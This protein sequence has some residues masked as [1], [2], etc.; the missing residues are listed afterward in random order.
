MPMKISQ[1]IRYI[2]K[3][4]DELS[5]RNFRVKVLPLALILLLSI[6]IGDLRYIDQKLVIFGIDSTVLIQIFF[7]LGFLPIIFLKERRVLNLLRLSVLIQAALLVTQFFMAPGV[8]RL[9]AY[10]GFHFANGIST[11]CGFYLFAFALNNVERLFTIVAAKSYFALSYLFL[12]IKPVAAFF[13]GAGSAAVMLALA[14]TAFAV[15]RR[16]K[17]ESPLF[18]LQHTPQFGTEPK[19]EPGARESGMAAVIVLSMVYFVITLMTLYIE[20]NEATVSASLFGIGGVASIA[21]IFTV[22]LLFNYSALHLWT[23]SLVS[24]VLG[25]G[26]LFYASAFAVN[27]GSL[28]YGVGEGLGFMILYYLQGG[29][30]KRSGSF[31]LLQ[32]F[33]LFTFANYAIVNSVFYALFNHLNAP[34]LNLAFP[35]VFLLTLVCLFLAPIL[36]KRLFHTDWTDGYHM[37]DMPF[38]VEAFK[39][40]EQ[41]DKKNDLGLT[42]R[43]REVFTLLLTDVPFKQIAGIMKVSNATVKF[44]SQNLYRKL[45]IQSRTELLV[46]YG[47]QPA[48][49]KTEKEF[50]MK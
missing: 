31:K 15:Y 34:N 40:V 48:D 18:S 3:T 33:C 45:N 14:A 12:Q 46:Q 5:L 11:V 29:A 32:L 1:S 24:S 19:Q 13:R 7:G 30:L 37:A 16:G 42:P 49:V 47:D 35:A 2:W 8:P 39:Q 22:M 6:M 9:T 17:A 28:L 50:A 20:H 38:Y 21:V 44:H 25:I 43:E 23:L 36:Y 27:T 4:R 26:L 10:L 41:V